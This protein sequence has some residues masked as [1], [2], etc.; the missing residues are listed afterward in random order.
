MDLLRFLIL[1]LFSGSIHAGFVHPGLMHT[2]AD[3]TRMAQKVSANKSPWIDTYNVLLSNGHSSLSYTPD[4]QAWAERGSGCVDNSRNVMNDAAAAYQLALVWKITGNTSY[5]DKAVSILNGWASTLKGI[6]CNAS[7]SWDFILMAG[8]QG[9]QFANA[10]EIMRSYSGF[11]ASNLT[12]FKSWMR[13][14]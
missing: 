12:A 2:Q 1:A 4:P 8:T 7:S 14:V 10:G 3:F 6:G 11:S 5:A 9:Y 13:N